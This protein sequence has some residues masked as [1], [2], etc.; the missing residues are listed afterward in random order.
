MNRT[1]P[2]LRLLFLLLVFGA[3]AQEVKPTEY[4]LKAAFIYHFAQFV[5][6]PP[7]TFP[8]ATSPFVIG[9]LGENPFGPSLAQAI[10]GKNLNEHPVVV[11][12]LRALTEAT[13]HLQ[14]L[15]ISSSETR[16]LPE[17][18]AALRD[19]NVLTIGETDRFL[20]SGG[21]INFVREGTKIR[22]QINE[23]AAKNAG[24]KISSKLLSLAT[25]KTQ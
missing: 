6:W 17:I 2:G 14:I 15:F 12:E 10:Q 25:R 4:Q 18:F 11:K 16:R 22:F 8:D 5:N 9:V 1:L 20:E 7:S 19:S 21:M 24:L 13:N 23:E 3:R